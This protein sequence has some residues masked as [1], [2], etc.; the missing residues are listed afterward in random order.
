MIITTT[1]TVAFLLP[2]EHELLERF[3][4]SNNMEEWQ[5]ETA[6]NMTMFTRKD[7]Q[8]RPA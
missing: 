7:V 8:Y 5:E 4:E 1:T 6:T 3:K 2:S